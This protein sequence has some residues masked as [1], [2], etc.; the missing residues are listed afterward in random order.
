MIGGAAPVDLTAAKTHP[1]L[2][3]GL[4]VANFPV[5]SETFV[6]NKAAGLVERGHTVRILCMDGQRR[7]DPAMH[8]TVARHALAKTVAKP[9]AGRA[10]IGSFQRSDPHWS[11]LRRGASFAAQAGMFVRE[12][13]F[14]IVHCQF[15]N[16]GLELLRHLQLGLLRTEHLVVHVRGVDIS[17]VVQA[18]GPEHYG[19]LFQRASLFIANCGY[20]RDKA[21]G[22]GVHPDKIIV[23]GS[24]IDCSQFAL[25]NY[26]PRRNDGVR[27]VSVGRLVEKKG[28][29]YAI[30]G[31]AEASGSIAGLRYDIVGEG[32]LREPLSALI[33]ELGMGERIRLL[34]ALPHEDVVRRLSEADILL[35]TSVTAASGDED[36]PV[37]SLKEA[38]AVGLPVIATQHGGLPELVEDGVH[39]VLVPQYDASAIADAIGTLLHR[40]DDWP[41]MGLAGR[42][43]VIGRYDLPHVTEQTIA[44]YRKLLNPMET[45]P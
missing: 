44:A 16:L 25:K 10:L 17:E 3:V 38:M 27:L 21:I 29:E 7:A 31:V 43:K 2:R 9:L 45:Q 8:G 34:G 39:G 13:A 14:Q 12:P 37:N 1:R 4:V 28:Y 23:I 26:A 20:F 15:A 33:E 5:I 42:Q 30:R 36:A 6:I 11:L 19:P 32:H 35:A 41:A 22:L 18:K 24:A 40:R